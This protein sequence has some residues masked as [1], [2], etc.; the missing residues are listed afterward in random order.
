MFKLRN[1]NRL[2]DV[3]AVT[4]SLLLHGILFFLLKDSLFKKVQFSI[5]SG[6]SSIAVQLIAAPGDEKTTVKVSESKNKFS[7]A[8]EKQ[9]AK[10]F[11]VPVVTSFPLKKSSLIEKFEKSKTPSKM[12]FVNVETSPENLSPKKLVQPLQTSS[13]VSGAMGQGHLAGSDAETLGSNK[14]GSPIIAQPDYLRN[15]PP[16]YPE[17][18]RRLREEGTVWLKTSVNVKGRATQI[19][20]V[21]SSGF[22]RLDKAAQ[23]SV[24]Q[25]RFRPAQFAGLAV[26]S[27]VEIPIIFQLK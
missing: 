18:S 2:S 8:E 6:N 13:K 1:I 7:S 20:I 4:V 14:K 19:N 27:M 23:N 5:L 26:E 25:W 15:P 3:V 12:A 10:K 11:E 16:V 22:D 24:R 21:K 17:I 9:D